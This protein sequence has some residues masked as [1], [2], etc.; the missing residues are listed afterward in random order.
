M[1]FQWHYPL[2]P[3]CPEVSAWNSSFWDD[4]MTQACG[5]ADEIAEEWERRHRR[6]CKQC[7]EYGA[8]NVD[9]IEG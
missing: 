7:Q 8:A 4:P 9:V 2:D 6:K 3:S 5:C 1:G